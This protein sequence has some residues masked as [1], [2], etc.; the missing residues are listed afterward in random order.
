MY[1]CVYI[2]ADENTRI[3][4][5]VSISGLFCSLCFFLNIFLLSLVSNTETPDCEGEAKWVCSTPPTL[6]S[7]PQTHMD[8]I[9]AK[10]TVSM[11]VIVLSVCQCP[12]LYL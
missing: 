8:V 7:I 10:D 11:C 5:I 12:H 1:Y 2:Y 4:D 9:R 6:K 3:W